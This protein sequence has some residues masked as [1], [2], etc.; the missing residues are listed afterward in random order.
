MKIRNLSFGYG[1]K[2]VLDNISLDFS[3][4]K[5]NVILGQNGAGKTTLFDLISGAL[6]SKGGIIDAPREEEVVYQ[7]QSVPFLYI[8]KG[9]D[10]VKLFFQTDFRSKDAKSAFKTLDQREEFL[11]KKLWE[12]PYGKMS[13]GERRWLIV[14]LICQMDRKVY[15]FDEPTSGVDPDSRIKILKRI[16]DLAKKDGRL[17]LMSTHILHELEY[18]DSWLYLLNGG[19][20]SFQ[21]SYTGFLEETGTT[22]PD[23]AFN[24]LIGVM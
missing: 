14:S 20:I 19:T 21:G 6:D 16:E 15:I 24:I 7:L 5:V 23:V 8:L 3:P 18:V 17:V 22:N 4:D 9:K 2:T 12:T 1:D 13:L 11:L 10:I